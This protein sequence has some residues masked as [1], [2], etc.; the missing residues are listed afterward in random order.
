MMLYTEDVEDEWRFIVW[1]ARKVKDV[2]VTAGSRSKEYEKEKQR[3][4]VLDMR[5]ACWQRHE[6]SK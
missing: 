4:T 3:N 2:G 1:A 6:H 5:T